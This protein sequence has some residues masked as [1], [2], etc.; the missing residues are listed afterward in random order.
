MIGRIIGAYCEGRR[1]ARHG[2][3]RK[4]RRNRAGKV[5]EDL[6]LRTFYLLGVEDERQRMHL[7]KRLAQFELEL[8]PETPHADGPETVSS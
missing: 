4:L 1:D 7:D 2:K 6:H 8:F 3:R 5:I